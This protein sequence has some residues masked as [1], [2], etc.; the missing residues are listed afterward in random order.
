MIA[1]YPLC[2]S[3][4]RQELVLRI[5]TDDPKSLCKLG[6]KFG[7]SLDSTGYILRTAK[8][9][10]LNVIGI[11]RFDENAFGDAVVRVCKVFDQ[12]AEI[13]CNFTLLVGGF[14]N[15]NIQDGITF[16]KV[17]AILGPV[18]TAW[19][20]LSI[21]PPTCE[22]VLQKIRMWSITTKN[23]LEFVTWINRVVEP[24]P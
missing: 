6:L 8:E 23:G 12:A 1:F 4:W 7:A 9:L 3:T 20:L 14:P 13:G 19:R 17:A 16:E 18:V 2:R 21:L 11:S 10:E 24:K 15:A 22:G 5:L